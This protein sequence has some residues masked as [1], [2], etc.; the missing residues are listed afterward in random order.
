MAV[1]VGHQEPGGVE[2][3]LRLPVEERGEVPPALL[4]VV[5]EGAIVHLQPGR[6]VSTG[7]ERSHH[8]R[9]RA[10][11]HLLGEGQADPELQE[12]ALLGEPQRGGERVLAG[13]RHWGPVA[14]SSPAPATDLEGGGGE[15]VACEVVGVVA[16]GRVDH[17]FHRPRPVGVGEV[18]VAGDGAAF[19]VGAESGEPV[20]PAGQEVPLVLLVEGAVVVDGSGPGQ[21]PRRS[22]PARPVRAGPPPAPGTDPSVQANAGPPRPG[23]APGRRRSG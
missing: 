18:G 19:F 22:R 6:L 14:Q 20:G 15:Q 17:H 1:L 9:R 13:G 3:R 4:G 7:P 10:A 12:V 8:H 16:P 2:P 5:G 21:R 11:A 23:E